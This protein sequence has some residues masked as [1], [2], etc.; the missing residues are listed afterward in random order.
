MHPEIPSLCPAR[1]RTMLILLLLAGVSA[2]VSAQSRAT[3]VLGGVVP[4]R[5]NVTF[6]PEKATGSAVSGTLADRSAPGRPYQVVLELPGAARSVRGGWR[7]SL[8]GHAIPVAGGV[9]PL[10]Q[11]PTLSGAPVRSFT[12]EIDR[13]PG[14]SA[15]AVG[16]RPDPIA[17]TVVAR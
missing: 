12:L 3:L 17:I 16:N 11:S 9:A 2:C 7:V 6:T 1:T 8:N 13:L 10:Y 4:A 5:G 15:A 14:Q